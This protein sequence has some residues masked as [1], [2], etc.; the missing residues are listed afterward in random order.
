VPS[1]G[2][3]PESSPL[4]R[5]H[6][7][8]AEAEE[9]EPASPQQF[10]KRQPVTGSSG[11]AQDRQHGL[12]SS[13]N[14]ASSGL[15]PVYEHGH[16]Q[17]LARLDGSRCRDADTEG[18]PSARPRSTPVKICLNLSL[19]QGGDEMLLTKC[20]LAPG[21]RGARP[22][23]YSGR[24]AQ[25]WKTGEIPRNTR[26]LVLAWPPLGFE[27][28][29][30]P[31]LAERFREIAL[32]FATFLPYLEGISTPIARTRGEGRGRFPARKV[33]LRMSV[34]REEVRGPGPAVEARARDADATPPAV[35]RE[36]QT[37]WKRPA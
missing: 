27:R 11:M 6:L 2:P 9:P 29:S 26:L 31:V 8:Q 25:E 13:R 7:R 36:T 19:C 5:E 32:P 15:Q 12:K 22:H 20:R 37:L 17:V 35:H 21:P 18:I 1:P 24:E 10:S 4:R 33:R 16:T 14:V 23:G 3:G 28:S 34:P 30:P